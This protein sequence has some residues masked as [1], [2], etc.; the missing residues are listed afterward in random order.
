ML[1]FRTWSLGKITALFGVLAV[2]ATE[3]WYKQYLVRGCGRTFFW[4]AGKSSNLL[5]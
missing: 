5:L 4:L 1:D 2:Y 3:K